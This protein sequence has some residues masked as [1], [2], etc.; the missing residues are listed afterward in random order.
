MFSKIEQ[1]LNSMESIKDSLNQNQDY[2]HD[3]YMPLSQV[4]LEIA[5]IL[6]SHNEGLISLSDQTLRE[7]TSVLNENGSQYMVIIE[8]R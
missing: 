4:K 6:Q 5:K 2:R 1:E 7:L 3:Q 8:R